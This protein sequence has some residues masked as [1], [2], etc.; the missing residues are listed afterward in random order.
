MSHQPFETWLLEENNR[1]PEQEAALQAHLL[2]CAECRQ[3]H[4][5][6]QEARLSL[7]SAGWPARHPASASAFRLLW[8]HVGLKQAHRRQ[9][10]NLIIG[11]SLGLIATAVLLTAVIFTFTSPVR[12]IGEWRGSDHGGCKPVEPDDPCAIRGHA[13]AHFPGSLDPGNL[14]GEHF[15]LWLVVLALADF[16]A[17]STSRM[18]KIIKFTL[19]FLIIAAVLLALPGSVYA[20]SPTSD[21]SPVI[22]GSDYVLPPGRSSKTWLSLGETR[23]SNKV[24]EPPGM[25]SSLAGI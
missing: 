16:S 5:G 8:Q 11:L 14:R 1:T 15:S 6:W 18:N 13:A 21:D 17:R 19:F 24:R 25:W 20:Q 7:K 23:Q 9:I 12:V 10:R 22:F 4:T 3:I 2:N